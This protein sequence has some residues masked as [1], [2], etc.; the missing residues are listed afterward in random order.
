M[1][2][3][4]GQGALAFD[5]SSPFAYDS[6]IAEP[7]RP[8]YRE[9][10]RTVPSGYDAATLSAS[11]TNVGDTDLAFLTYGD[12]HSRSVAVGATRAQPRR[13]FVDLNRNRAF[14]PDEEMPSAA[15]SAADPWQL[16]LDAEFVIGSNQFE[17]MRRR[18][19][20]RVNPTTNATEMAT[21]GCLRGTT[22]IDNR[23]VAVLRVD[24]NANGLWFDTEDRVWIDVN[25][26][27]RFAPLQEKFGCRTTCTLAG[28]PYAV[29]ADDRGAT[30]RL[31]R[32]EG[33]GTLVPVCACDDE[34]GR[35]TG[36]QATLVSNTGVH[37]FLRDASSAV[38]VPVGTYRLHAVQVTLSDARGHWRMVFAHDTST[39]SP[40]WEVRKGEKIDIPL[41]GE[42]TLGA[43]KS[44][45]Q[46][47]GE[48]ILVVTPHVTT[49]TGLYVTI[50]LM[51]QSAASDPN[52]AQIRSTIGTQVVDVG[53]SG[54]T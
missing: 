44:L 15:G 53:T 2:V 23:S 50:C 25:G 41:I 13:L 12:T 17:H 22:P 42:L 18:V 48:R 47:H 30:F 34:Q 9:L 16:D 11:L 49:S 8:T 19:A 45:R 20:I 4:G 35:V 1:L 32:I 7:V 28:T 36:C 37:V 43:N 51:G 33:T 10:S 24:C 31:E 21:L 38:E 6:S 39:K 40:I 27:S 14:E 5:D 52:C 46:P 26:D 29:A 3:I 54:F